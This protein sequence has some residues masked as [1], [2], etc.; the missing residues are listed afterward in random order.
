[1]QAVLTSHHLHENYSI[2]MKIRAFICISC[3][4]VNEEVCVKLVTR[5]SINLHLCSFSKTSD[6]NLFTVLFSWYFYFGWDHS[7]F[8]VS[9]KL[10]GSFRLRDHSDLRGLS[11]F[12]QNV[13][14]FSKPREILCC[15]RSTRLWKEVSVEAGCPHF[16]NMFKQ[17]CTLNRIV[18]SKTKLAAFPVFIELALYSGKTSSTQVKFCYIKW[19]LSTTFMYQV[20]V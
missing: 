1:M 8:G 11:D 5:V 7:D 10:K 4:Y 14:N 3:I 9:F 12:A 20:Y 19:E 6:N 2:Y 17:G 15:L 13:C 18:L 16:V